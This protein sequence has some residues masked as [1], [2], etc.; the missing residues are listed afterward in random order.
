MIEERR[1]V[2]RRKNYQQFVNRDLNKY[3]SSCVSKRANYLD[4]K[5]ELNTL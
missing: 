2:K 4:K 5:I 1:K 3:H